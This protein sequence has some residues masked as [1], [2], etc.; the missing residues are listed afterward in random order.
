MRIKM[1][2]Y[3]RGSASARALSRALG[4]KRLNFIRTNFVP[5]NNDA[6]INWGSTEQRFPDDYYFNPPANVALATNKATALA[7]LQQAGVP[8]PEFTNDPAIATEWLVGGDKVVARTMLR[9]SGG[10][11]IVLVGPDDQLPPA[12]LYT[13]Y[14]KKK[15]EYRIHVFCGG[16][17]AVQQKRR[18]RD[19]ERLDNQI[20]N[21]VNG[22]VFCRKDVVP[23]DNAVKL[24]AKSAVD[25]LGLDF[26]AVDIGWNEY[27]G[28]PCVYEVNTAPGLEG[29]T[30]DDYVKAFK[31][32]LTE[33]EGK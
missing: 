32:V 12:P 26:G 18:Q 6:I 11:G 17:I 13:K 2:T 3:I 22:W 4:I 16:I 33:K 27:R 7:A 15:H 31:N 25:A 9:A 20:R 30:L 23:P 28:E 1:Q 5:N 29:S 19:A 8:V 21:H 14:V 10:R 24:A